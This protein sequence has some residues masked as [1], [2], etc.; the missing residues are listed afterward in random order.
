M[1]NAKKKRKIER[2]FEDLRR[3]GYAKLKGSR[4]QLQAGRDALALFEEAENKCTK[5]IDR[6]DILIGKANSYVRSRQFQQALSPATAAVEITDKM[7]ARLISSSEVDNPI[8]Q[9]ALL[10]IR[11]LSCLVDVCRKLHKSKKKKD[12]CEKMLQ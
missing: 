9:K 5:E 3:E 10:R 1:E 7:S 2:S 6:A 12:L 11:A 4:E 8:S